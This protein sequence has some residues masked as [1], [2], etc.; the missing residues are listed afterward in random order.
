MTD[1][2]LDYEQ[3]LIKEGH[4]SFLPPSKDLTTHPGNK[5]KKK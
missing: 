4:A 2:V 1:V 5:I 3:L